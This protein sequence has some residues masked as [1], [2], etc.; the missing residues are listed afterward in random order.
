MLSVRLRTSLTLVALLVV[1]SACL[2]EVTPA[3]PPPTSPPATTPATT[4]TPTS[5][6]PV[7]AQPTTTNPAAA[8]VVGT[9]HPIDA[10]A[11]VWLQQHAAELKGLDGPADNFGPF[12][13]VVNDARIVLLAQPTFGA[14]EPLLLQRQLFQH[15]VMELGFRG[16]ALEAPSGAVNLLNAYLQTGE[17]VPEQ[18]LND[19][20]FLNWNNQELLYLVKWMRAYNVRADPASRLGIYGIDFQT[21]R[22]AFNFM[23]LSSFMRKVDEARLDFVDSHLRCFAAYLDNPSAYAQ[24][25]ANVTTECHDQL[26]QLYDDI[27]SRQAQYEARSSASEFATILHTV[28]VTLQTEDYAANFG[29]P[30]GF[31][32][33]EQ[34]LAENIRWIA[35]QGG[36]DMKLMVWAQMTHADLSAAAAPQRMSRLLRSQYGDALRLIGLSFYDGSFYAPLQSGDWPYV[37][38][39]TPAPNG[40][41]EELFHRGGLSRAVIDLRG[42]QPDSPMGRWFSTGHLLR[43]VGAAYNEGLPSTYFSRANLPG[44]LDALVFLDRVSPSDL[45]SQGVITRAPPELAVPTNLNFKEGMTGWSGPTVDPS[46]YESGLDYAVTHSGGASAYVKASSD[47]ISDRTSLSQQIFG[48]LYRGKRIR[49]TAYLRS[50]NV[51]VAAGLFLGDDSMQGQPIAGTTDWTR[52][53]LVVDVPQDVFPTW[54]GLWLQGQGQVW[55]DDLHLE[56]VG[57]NVPLTYM[58]GAATMIRNGGFEEGL[59]PWLPA[60]QRNFLFVL[61]PVVQHSGTAS[62]KI[63]ARSAASNG[64]ALLSQV[65]DPQTYAGK[66]IRLSGYIRANEVRSSA[67]LWIGIQ[68]T[69]YSLDSFQRYSQPISGTTE[70]VKSEIIL[71]VP[72]E[73]NFAVIGVTL[74]GTGMIWLDDF[75]IEL[76]GI[77]TPP[78]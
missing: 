40:S 38:H 33:R 10:D 4:P 53:E 42:I 43:G 1:L 15:M 45:R 7:P 71:D 23:Q 76:V 5:I 41:V 59:R 68:G 75:Q 54:L 73:S 30:S 9:T 70:W 63:Q 65:F 44:A 14:H 58:F 39:V 48:D 29:G 34:Y 35:E 36:P 47:N 28:R 27:T 22:L 8:P 55:M 37:Q 46:G 77:A 21:V 67:I 62:L 2:A 74:E 18:I 26:Q 12:Y 17:G 51:T 13:R 24:L 69:N 6:P 78:P 60:N 20:D 19:S 16:L 66:R 52:Y 49:L 3:T 32:L 31:A 50:E 61:D 25:P 11:L 64:S 57:K 72:P 56:I